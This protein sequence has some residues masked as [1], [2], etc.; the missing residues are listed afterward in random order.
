MF[1]KTMKQALKLYG[2]VCL[3]SVMG[4]FVFLSVGAIFSMID[5]NIAQN[6]PLLFVRDLVALLLQGTMFFLILYHKMWELG[7]KNANAAAFGRIKDNAWRGLHIGLLAS[8]PAFL[9]YVALVTDKLFALWDG[10]ALVY[11]VGQ[12]GLYP[13]IVWSMGMSVSVPSS[14]ISWGGIACAA[15]P[16]LFVPFASALAYYLGYRHISVAEKLIFVQ[17]K[18]Q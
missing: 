18:E 7:D 5:K 11:R 14:E 13:V 16:L 17:N 6:A 4:L 8:V 3:A 9:S 15:L 10:M 2:R 1:K 12:M